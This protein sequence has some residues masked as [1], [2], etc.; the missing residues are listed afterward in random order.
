MLH[1]IRVLVL[2]TTIISG[3]YTFWFWLLVLVELEFLGGV[4]GFGWFFGLLTVRFLSNRIQLSLF[5]WLQLNHLT[6][7]LWRRL[8]QLG[9]RPS[10]PLVSLDVVL[11]ARLQRRRLLGLFLIFR[12]A[13]LPPSLLRR[14]KRI[15]GQD[16]RL[17]LAGLGPVFPDHLPRLIVILRVVIVTATKYA[18]FFLSHFEVTFESVVGALEL[19]EFSVL[20][21]NHIFKVNDLLLQLVAS[22]L[23]LR[24]QLQILLSFD[25]NVWLKV[26]LF[27]TVFGDFLVIELSELGLSIL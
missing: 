6:A 4:R 17:L 13:I 9:W 5:H 23:H 21:L 11:V 27:F 19:G 22:L 8:F 3:W 1:Y 15:G 12:L 7:F 26:W 24:F 14:L 16:Q 2:F 20:T 25:F 10:R 18:D